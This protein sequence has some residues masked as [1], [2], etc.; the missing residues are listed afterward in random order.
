M[1]YWCSNL[2]LVLLH[3]QKVRINNGNCSDLLLL[4][5]MTLRSSPRTMF[6][7][8]GKA[9]Y[10]R[11]LLWRRRSTD[12]EGLT[13][14]ETGSRD[15]ISSTFEQ[16]DEWLLLED[17]SV[18]KNSRQK[19]LRCSITE[20]SIRRLTNLLGGAGLYKLQ[21]LTLAAMLCRSLLGEIMTSWPVCND[22]TGVDY[23]MHSSFMDGV[24]KTSW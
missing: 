21:E 1:F 16:W 22:P 4:W 11:D 13:L 18:S 12:I 8:A 17:G 23:R 3:E 9:I 7:A 6:S 10:E 14:T 15:V 24:V 19:P 5:S 2:T 20:T